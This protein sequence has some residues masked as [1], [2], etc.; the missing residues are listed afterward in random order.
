MMGYSS[1]RILIIGIDGG[2]FDVICSM[3]A[4]GEVEEL[5]THIKSR[6]SQLVDESKPQLEKIK[7][8]L[9]GPGYL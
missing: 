6:F 2:T 7:E 5:I 1:G 8:S 3:V 9:K 4:R